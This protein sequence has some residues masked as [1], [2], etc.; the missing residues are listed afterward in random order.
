[1]AISNL[2]RYKKDLK[3]LIDGG[4]QLHMAMQKECFPTEFA[5]QVKAALPKTEVESLLKALPDFTQVYQ[6]WYSEAK[7]LVKQLLPDRLEDFVAHYET[8]RNRKEVT[9]ATYRILDYLQGLTITRG[10]QKEKI[11]GPDAAIPQFRQQLAIVKAIESR[12]E[13]SLF[14]IRQLVQADLFDSDLD[15]AEELAKKKFT[16]AAGA[17][18]GVVLERHLAQ[19]CSNHGLKLTKK[20]P[21]IADLNDALKQANVIDVPDW[22]FTQHL[23]DLRN[24]CDHNKATDPTSDQV[25]ELIAGVRKV[26][27]T[28]F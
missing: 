24:L 2:E 20:S 4:N 10:N 23:A 15:A 28:L 12:F 6:R 5:A 13:S 9:Y 21:T 8:P 18:A 17:M 27:K 22:R 26:S 11:V 19:V 25:N 16:R 14:D 3:S 1:M 7:V